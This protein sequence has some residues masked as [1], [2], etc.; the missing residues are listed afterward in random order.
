MDPPNA[1]DLFSVPLPD[2]ITERKRMARILRD[3]GRLGEAKAIEKIPRPTVPAWT[4]N[5]I[6]RQD[7]KLVRLLSAL[8]SQL[9][10]A[11]GRIS[12][13]RGGA[14]EYAGAA[15]EHRKILGALRIKAV[16]VLDGAG[17]PASPQI[18]RRV[19]ANL[20]GGVAS[21]E[22]RSLV[23]EGRMSRDVEEKD[24][25]ALFE[26]A[27]PDQP[28]QKSPGKPPQTRTRDTSTPARPETHR[29]ARLEARQAA[30]EEARHQRSRQAAARDEKRALA[31]ARLALERRVRQLRAASRAA[32]GA[33]EKQERANAVA[34]QTLAES[35]SR[36][37]SARIKAETAGRELERTEAELAGLGAG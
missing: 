4:V 32:R 14:A 20:R 27:I 28:P 6:A 24:F 3:A 31:R 16:E 21:P 5:Q 12:A 36:L 18:L 9:H 29:E 25:T 8:T 11:Q 13:E 37:Q 1:D 22:T 35:E 26:Q 34:R 19:I 23:E 2:F 15:L 30:R 17:H 10:L 7:P 33:L